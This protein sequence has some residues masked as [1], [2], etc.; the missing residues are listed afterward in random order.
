LDKI[1]ISSDEEEK[2]AAMQET[3]LMVQTNTPQVVSPNENHEIHIQVHSQAGGNPIVDQHILQHGQMLGLKQGGKI[4]ML[5]GAGGQAGVS[6]LPQEGDIRPPM[7]ST[8]PEITRQG[9]TNAGD[10]YQSVQNQ[11][12]GSKSPEQGG[13]GF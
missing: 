7:S 3:Q 11:G 12:V 8:N 6:N 2:N 10:I 13:V 9:G 4:P 5:E 1:V